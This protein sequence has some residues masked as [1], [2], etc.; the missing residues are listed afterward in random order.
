M[1]QILSPFLHTGI[2]IGRIFSFVAE[3][4]TDKIYVQ[5]LAHFTSTPNPSS[6][7]TPS[8]SIIRSAP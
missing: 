3:W 5:S 4:H 7:I 6:R 1:P 2:R 8:T